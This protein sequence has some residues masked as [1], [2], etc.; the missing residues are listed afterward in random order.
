VIEL[1]YLSG[2]VLQ[3]TIYDVI[4]DYINNNEYYNKVYRPIQ[5][6]DT[7]QLTDISGLFQNTSFN[8]YIGDW[9]VSNVT[10]MENLF[11]DATLFDKRVSKWNVSNVTNMDSM[12]E[13]ATSFNKSLINWTKLYNIEY[14][15]G[16][17]IQANNP[18]L[19]QSLSS[20]MTSS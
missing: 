2:N 12:F 10:N 20:K 13:G 6:L 7:T 5:A 14:I 16:N 11:K 18:R 9:D 8:S 1:L 4:D 19:L 3:E 15:D 17:T